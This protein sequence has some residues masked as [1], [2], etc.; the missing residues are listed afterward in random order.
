MR[1]CDVTV[2][3]H[4]PMPGEVFAEIKNPAAC[5][6]NELAIRK[7]AAYVLGFLWREQL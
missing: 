5:E 3:R 1:A 6:V 7:T 4:M 2:V